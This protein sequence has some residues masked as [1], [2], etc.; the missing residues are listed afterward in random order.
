MIGQMEVS[1]VGCF[2]LGYR[3]GYNSNAVRL[4]GLT[5]V[6]T[7]AIANPALVI[8][9][10]ALMWQWYLTR[11]RAFVR[12]LGVHL[13]VIHSSSWRLMLLW[14]KAACKFVLTLMLRAYT[15]KGESTRRASNKILMRHPGFNL[16]PR[17]LFL[18][19]PPSAP[20]PRQRD[21]RPFYAGFNPEPGIPCL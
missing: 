16:P 1:I 5:V 17:P 15:Y 13:S 4:I 8:Q 19:I 14:S 18:V 2:R 3:I 12:S 7:Q 21:L 11:V 9:C 20:L 6:L 10:V